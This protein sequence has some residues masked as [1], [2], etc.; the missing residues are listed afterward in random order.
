MRD[1]GGVIVREQRAVAAN[2]V[3]QV[4]H[5]LEVG[6]NVRVVTKEVRV[7][8]LDV[9]HMLDVVAGGRELAAGGGKPSTGARAVRPHFRGRQSSGNEACD[10]KD[11]EESQASPLHNYLPVG[12]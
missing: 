2:E 6:W 12:L 11:P 10:Q 1:Q 3:E 4:R 9:D 8:E 7:V 5:L